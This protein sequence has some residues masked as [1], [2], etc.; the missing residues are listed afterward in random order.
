MMRS[1]LHPGRPQS[2]ESF[3]VTKRECETMSSLDQQLAR[4]S[5]Q[6]KFLRDVITCVHS[7]PYSSTLMH[8]NCIWKSDMKI[9]YENYILIRPETDE[10]M[11]IT[12]LI[13]SKADE[14]TDEI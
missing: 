2:T 3:K 10:C 6:T 12:Y 8:G 14:I 9:R 13:T 1:C 7:S 5:I 11:K 4:N